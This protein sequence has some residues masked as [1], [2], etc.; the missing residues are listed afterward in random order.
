M[1]LS[2]FS[3]AADVKCVDTC[4]TSPVIISQSHQTASSTDV[5]LRTSLCVLPETALLVTAGMRNYSS[6]H[7]G[8][9]ESNTQL[10]VLSVKLPSCHVVW[11]LLPRLCLSSRWDQRHYVFG[12]SVHLCVHVCMIGQM[13]SLTCLL[14][15]SSLFIITYYFNSFFISF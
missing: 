12:L 14:S 4:S 5:C 3:A 10:F 8:H 11:C 2:V 1:L 15:A 13:H 9:E 6:H 7:G